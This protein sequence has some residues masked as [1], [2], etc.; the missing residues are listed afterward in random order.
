MLDPL[1][2]L[3]ARW[4]HLQGWVAQ[5]IREGSPGGHTLLRSPRQVKGMETQR[6]EQRW[7][8]TVTR[9]CVCVYH[10]QAHNRSHPCLC[11]SMFLSFSVFG[12]F[13]FC[14]PPSQFA[15]Y[16]TSIFSPFSGKHGSVPFFSLSLLSPSLSSSLSSLPLLL[17]LPP[18]PA[19]PNLSFSAC[20]VNPPPRPSLSASLSL[21]LC[22]SDSGSDMTL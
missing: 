2:I 17:H 18:Y 1:R 11:M 16:L 20:P 19:S 3:D 5:V 21:S 8:G 15:T 6:Q 7:A 22:L 4:Q 9:S 14:F 10:P 12:V 13:S